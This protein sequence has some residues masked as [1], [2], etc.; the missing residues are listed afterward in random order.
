MSFAINLR[1]HDGKHFPLTAEEYA[2]LADGAMWHRLDWL[3]SGDS[4][5]V[6]GE[7]P[8]RRE[9]LMRQLRRAVPTFRA[10]PAGQLSRRKVRCLSKLTE[11]L[12]REHG[13]TSMSNV[14]SALLTEYRLQELRAWLAETRGGLTIRTRETE[15]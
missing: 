7:P 1:T 15:A 2:V 9:S 11:V 6:S 14:R 13:E 10:T 5:F 4:G 3:P 12:L 8:T